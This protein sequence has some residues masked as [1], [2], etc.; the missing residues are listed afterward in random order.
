MAEFTRLLPLGLVG[1]DG[2]HE[3]IVASPAECAA[4]AERFGILGIDSLRAVLDLAPEADGS[5]LVRGS[6]RAEV[7]QAC[8][9]SLEPVTQQVE[10]AVAL[11]VLPPGREPADGP[12]DLD[13]IATAQGG[14][15]DLGEALAEQLSLALDPYPRAAGAELP[16]EAQDAPETPFAALAALKRGLH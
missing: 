2:R 8:V 7:T 15:A 5:V 10:E 9:V 3:E 1:P 6:L 16:A 14:V 13:E 11:R 12:D 4:L